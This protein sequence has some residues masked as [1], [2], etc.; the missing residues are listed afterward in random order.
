MQQ[1]VVIKPLDMVMDHDPQNFDAI[2]PLKSLLEVKYQ[3]RL[4]IAAQDP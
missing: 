4:A 1:V 3:A 2:M